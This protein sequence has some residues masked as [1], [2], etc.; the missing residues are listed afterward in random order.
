MNA[1]LSTWEIQRDWFLIDKRK[2]Y[3]AQL[4]LKNIEYQP[5]HSSTR[6]NFSKCFWNK[7][8][9]NVMMTSSYPRSKDEMP[10]IFA[11][12]QSYDNSKVAVK[13]RLSSCI[14]TTNLN[15][16]ITKWKRK[17]QVS[18]VSVKT[19][20][21]KCILANISGQILHLSGSVLFWI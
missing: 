20:D 15:V 6:R 5:K 16:V 13:Y 11:T 19:I 17:S 14:I 2:K 10:K 1:L 18:S 21:F 8:L 12:L 9:I 4:W 3:D 7:H